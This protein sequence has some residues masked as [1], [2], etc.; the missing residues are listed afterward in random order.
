[1]VL[2]SAEKRDARRGRGSSGGKRK[3]CLCSGESSNVARWP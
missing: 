2:A 1:M 3:V